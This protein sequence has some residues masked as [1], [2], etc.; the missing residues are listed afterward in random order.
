MN[1]TKKIFSLSS[2]GVLRHFSLSDVFTPVLSIFLH[3][4]TVWLLSPV[5]C[6]F[7]FP[8]WHHRCTCAGSFLS[9]LLVLIIVHV[10]AHPPW[11]LFFTMLHSMTPLQLSFKFLLSSIG[12]ELNRGNFCGCWTF[13]SY[14]LRCPSASFLSRSSVLPTAQLSFQWYESAYSSLKFSALPS[15]QAGCLLFI[16][17][18]GDSNQRPLALKPSTLSIVL[19]RLRWGCEAKFKYSLL[20]WWMPPLQKKK[21]DFAKQARLR[22][23]APKP[24]ALPTVLARLLWGYEAK[25][26]YS[27]LSWWMAP[28]KKKEEEKGS[29]LSVFARDLLH[30]SQGH[31]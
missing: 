20:R 29:L 18:F 19:A 23:P 5:F 7:V 10:H 3:L 31:S 2:H 1:S 22:S 8:L 26:K 13:I 27:L 6:F 14:C 28:P 24:S 21:K 4:S 9:P 16:C 25:F 11:H 30:L 15:A 17:P 12:S